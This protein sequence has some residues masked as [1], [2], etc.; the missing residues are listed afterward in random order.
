MFFRLNGEVWTEVFAL[1]AVGLTVA[2]V[3]GGYVG[4]LS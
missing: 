2:V 1:V 3:V 4:V